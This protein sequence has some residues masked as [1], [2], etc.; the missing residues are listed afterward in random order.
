MLSSLFLII[1]FGVIFLLLIIS[2]VLAIFG[3]I[4]R[5]NFKKKTNT[6]KKTVAKKK[7]IF[8]KDEGEYV[9]YEEIDETK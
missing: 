5:I 1:I 2:A 6:S 8:T 7:K 9:D 4:F 3:S